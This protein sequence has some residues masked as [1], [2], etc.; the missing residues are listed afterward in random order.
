MESTKSMC[1]WIVTTE[2]D[3]MRLKGFALPENMVSL[4]IEFTI[5]DGFYEAVF[6]ENE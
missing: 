5:D 4:A 6:N 2:K 1:D 3:I